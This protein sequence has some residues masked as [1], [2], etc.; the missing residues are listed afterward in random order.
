[1]RRNPNLI[2]EQERGTARPISYFFFFFNR[3]TS[4][5]PV[6]FRS[7][8]TCHVL[9]VRRW[10]GLACAQRRHVGLSAPRGDRQQG[11]R[12]QYKQ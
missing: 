9:F 8:R 7:M 5:R 2:V 6:F 11:K 3:G 12:E 10:A 4:T 1:M